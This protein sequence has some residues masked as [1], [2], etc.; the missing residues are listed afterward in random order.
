MAGARGDRLPDGVLMGGGVRDAFLG[1][2]GMGRGRGHE[3]RSAAGSPAAA[4][5]APAAPSTPAAA[6]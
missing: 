4:P 6:A 5:V 1:G 3:G 2:I